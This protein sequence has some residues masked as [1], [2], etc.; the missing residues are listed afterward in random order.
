PRRDT[1][2]I[3][4]HSVK[5]CRT[6]D[7]ADGWYGYGKGPPTKHR[8]GRRRPPPAR[9]AKGFHQR[10][11]PAPIGRTHFIDAIVGAVERR[12]SCDLDRRESTVIE[13]RFYPPE[14]RD[15][16]LV[17]DC[18]TDPPTRHRIGLRH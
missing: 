5:H 18:E 16:A 2:T 11:A 9:S 8:T 13:I 1:N 17:A 6:L 12:R 4:A 3:S 14:R 15:E 10:I 7:H